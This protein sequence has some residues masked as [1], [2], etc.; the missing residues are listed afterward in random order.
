MERRD[1]KEHIN[2]TFLKGLSTWREPRS[3]QFET[4]VSFG[5]KLEGNLTQTLV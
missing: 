5:E 3:D 2:W 1:P 4:R